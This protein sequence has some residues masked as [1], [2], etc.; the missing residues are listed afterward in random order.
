M[1]SLVSL[2]FLSL[3]STTLLAQDIPN[4]SNT[5]LKTTA[6]FKNA[7]PMVIACTNYLFST[8][9]SK[10]NLDR[11][12]ATQ[13]VLKWMEGTDYTFNIDSKMTDL[14]DG[15]DDLFGMYLAGMSKVVLENKD[16]TLSDDEIHAQVTKMLIDYCKDESHKCKPTK[17]MKKAM[18]G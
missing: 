15:N 11:L 5:P 18:K 2:L 12:V 8:S 6:D 13:F 4:V 3:V 1:K 17:K 9:V 10:D 14:T 16:A 7:E